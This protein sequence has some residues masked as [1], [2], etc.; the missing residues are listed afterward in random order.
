MVTDPH[1][2]RPK[3]HVLQIG[4][5]GAHSKLG[6]LPSLANFPHEQPGNRQMTRRDFGQDCSTAASTIGM[7]A[8]FAAAFA[9][10]KMI[11]RLRNVIRLGMVVGVATAERQNGGDEINHICS[12]SRIAV[13]QCHK[14]IP[15]LRQDVQ[16]SIDSRCAT[17]VTVSSTRQH[18]KTHAVIRA[19]RTPL[20]GLSQ[21]FGA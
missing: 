5:C 13:G 15:A 11:G 20:R 4:E 7:I 6:L 12:H 19:H 9:M 18:V 21:K 1:S 2:M 3:S 10:C 17:A 8:V 14:D 16:F